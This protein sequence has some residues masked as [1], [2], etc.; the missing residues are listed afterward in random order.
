MATCLIHTQPVL[1]LNTTLSSQ[2]G[3]LAAQLTELTSKQ[4]QQ[5]AAVSGN[6]G[7]TPILTYRS[8]DH[9]QLYCLVVKSRVI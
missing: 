8:Y 9:E 7:D 1:T 5:L 4:Q 2:S 3:P 6:C